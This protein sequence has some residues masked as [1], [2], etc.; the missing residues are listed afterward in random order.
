[1]TDV[2]DGGVYTYV[3]AGGGGTLLYFPLN[4][5][6]NLKVLLKKVVHLKRNGIMVT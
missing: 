3:G 5:A 4:F 6:K 2:D 1:M